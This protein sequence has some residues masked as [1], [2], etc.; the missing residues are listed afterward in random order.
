MQVDHNHENDIDFSINVVENQSLLIVNFNDHQTIEH[1]EGLVMEYNE[2]VQ[3]NKKDN[4][5]QHYC[6]ELCKGHCG[7]KSSSEILPN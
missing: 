1:P 7:F 6:G 2:K 3:Q 4:E 5:V